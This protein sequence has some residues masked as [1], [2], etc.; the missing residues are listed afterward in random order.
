MPGTIPDD[1]VQRILISAASLKARSDQESSNEDPE[2]QS[3]YLIKYV[4]KGSD[5]STERHLALLLRHGGKDGLIY[6]QRWYDGRGIYDVAVDTEDLLTIEGSIKLCRSYLPRLW[7]SVK[8]PW[9]ERTVPQ[10][11]TP[12]WLGT[13]PDLF[14]SLISEE[15]FF[16]SDK[17]G[18]IIDLVNEVI[19]EDDD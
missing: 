14:V 11:D 19:G 15:A 6:R 17:Y 4:I 9:T 13:D 5:G 12:P 10:E 2:E 3:T 1:N 16:E 7:N 18:E 8:K